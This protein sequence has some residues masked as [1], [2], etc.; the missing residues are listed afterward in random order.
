MPSAQTA[1]ILNIYSRKQTSL[2]HRFLTYPLVLYGGTNWG[3]TAAP[4]SYTSYDYGG[5]INENRVAGPKM[6]EM[7]LQ[8]T[9]IKICKVLA[10]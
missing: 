10:Q 1:T 9:R 8:G 3:Q 4:V 5:G 7:R 2:P 6:N